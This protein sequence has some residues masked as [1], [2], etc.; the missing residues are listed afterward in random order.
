MKQDNHTATPGPWFV[1]DGGADP[2]DIMAHKAGDLLHD[3]RQAVIVARTIFHRPGFFGHPNE[4]AA[5]AR[6][7]AAAPELLEALAGAA[8]TMG[9]AADDCEATGVARK[10][11]AFILRQAAI[12]IRAVLEKAKGT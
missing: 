6:L 9:S 2:P 11:T 12:T 4:V 5:N 1:V 3:R 7:I 10:Q 8:H